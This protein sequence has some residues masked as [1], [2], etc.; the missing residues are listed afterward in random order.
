MPVDLRIVSLGAGVQSSTM[1]WLADAG[2]ITPRPDYAVFA[3]TQQEPPWVYETLEY[4]QKNCS[5]PIRVATAGDLGACLT[6]GN[7]STG[8]RFASVPFWTTGQDG[9]EAPT[10]RQ[11]T[12]E[13]KIDV[14]KKEIRTLLGLKPGQRAAGK[15]HVEMW[16]GIS[17][18]EAGRAKP[19]RDSWI[20][21]RWPLLFDHPMRRGDCL[22]WM[23]AQG[24]PIPQRSACVFCPYR[25]AIDWADWR[26]NEPELFEQAC[27]WDDTI[28]MT[29]SGNQRG[30]L[31]QQYIL[32]TRVPLR[33]LPPTAELEKDD[34]SQLDLFEGDCETGMCGF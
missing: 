32:R 4:L 6:A 9:R 23:K 5:I 3:D 21:T 22:A 15:Y 25:R 24:H 20:T 13:Y 28:R 31:H 2:L 1:M 12:R 33:E 27:V 18:D 19:A 26:D 17:M 16:V 7:N 8:Q 30:M 29:N 34:A 14:V 10:R 11:C